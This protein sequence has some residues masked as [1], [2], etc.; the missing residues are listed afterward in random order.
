M[1]VARLRR[2]LLCCYGAV[3]LVVTLC[4]MPP[5]AA[6]AMLIT[7]S[8]VY[9]DDSSHTVG[10]G[11][12]TWNTDMETMTSLTWNFSGKVGTVLDSALEH[13]YHWYDP[14]ATTYGEL[15][16]RFFTDPRGYL[17]SQYNP[18]SI[19]VGLMP[20][21]VTGDFGFVAFGVERNMDD[22]SYIFYDRDW[23]EVSEGHV[24]TTP[25]PEPSSIA[26]VLAGLLTTGLVVA[27]RNRMR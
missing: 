6:N 7:Y 24:A 21:N 26:L 11:S 15:Y 27:I 3:T 14:R 18:L 10:T 22:A 19:S 5:S 4:I 12:Y 1:N 9:T 20:Y 2:Y 13:T 23:N 25:V 17:V 8:M 16:Y